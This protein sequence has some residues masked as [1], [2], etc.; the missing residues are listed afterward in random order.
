[1]CVCFFFCLK[2]IQTCFFLGSKMFLICYKSKYSLNMLYDWKFA[3][4]ISLDDWYVFLYS[5]YVF[6]WDPECLWFVTN[7][8][9]AQ[10]CFMI[11]NSQKW[12]IVDQ[13]SWLVCFSVFYVCFVCPKSIHICFFHVKILLQKLHFTE[14]TN[15]DN[16]HNHI[17]CLQAQIPLLNRFLSHLFI[18]YMIFR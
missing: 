1:M 15:C 11:K 10:I 9:I 4:V 7:L 6:S 16:F 3:E 14:Y 17:V 2:S 13:Q 8:N 18:L 5:V 12:Y